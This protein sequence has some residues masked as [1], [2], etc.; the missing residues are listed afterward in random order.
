MLL[1]KVAKYRDYSSF[2]KDIKKALVDKNMTATELA[3]K[4]GIKQQ[5]LNSVIHGNRS[6]EK[7]RKKI[8]EILD[9]V[10]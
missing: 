3:Y 9:L 8:I 10:A 1:R 4:L 6:G 7:Y 5:Y 2:G